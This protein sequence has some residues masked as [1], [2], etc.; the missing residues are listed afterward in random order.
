[1]STNADN[2]PFTTEEVAEMLRVSEGTVRRWVT[3]GKLPAT[4]IG[5]KVL[6]GRAAVM[7]IVDA[8]MQ[9]MQ[10][11]SSMMRERIA[12]KIEDTDPEIHALRSSK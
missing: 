5:A 2:K 10:G 8:S 6:I 9:T 4:K 7:N 3:E 11:T 12:A 1:M